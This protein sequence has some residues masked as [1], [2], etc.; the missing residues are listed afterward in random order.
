M[1]TLRFRIFWRDEYYVV[2]G[3]IVEAESWQALVSSKDFSKHKGDVIRIALIDNFPIFEEDD[4]EEDHS[5][6]T[7]RILRK[8]D[9]SLGRGTP[10]APL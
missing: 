5:H 6:D 1:A 4:E 7:T 3:D 8:S 10:S 9:T 2:R